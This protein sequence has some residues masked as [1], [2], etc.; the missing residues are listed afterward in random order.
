MAKTSVKNQNSA[1][2]EEN[3]SGSHPLEAQLRLRRY[4]PTLGYSLLI[5]LLYLTGPIFMMQVYDRVLAS[6]NI[7]TLIAL[8]FVVLVLYIFFGVLEYIRTQILTANGEAIVAR[9]AKPAYKLS[10]LE[11]TRAKPQD[12]KLNA[13]EDVHTL[14]S[15][16]CSP[17][18]GALFDLPWSPLFLLFVFS[19][20][21]Q[22]GLLALIA[23]IGLASLAIVNER[24]TRQS[25]QQANGISMAARQQAE[26]AQRN[27]I[28]LL[29]NGMLL[30]FGRRWR[31]TDYDAQQKG[32]AASAVNSGFSTV[33]KTVRLAIQSCMLGAGAY[34][35][36][37]GEMTAGAIIAGSVTFGR[38]LA[39]LE[40][41]LGN[42]SL[43]INGRRSWR[44]ISSWVKQDATEE[45]REPLPRPQRKLT[46]NQL[47]VIAPGSQKV[48]VKNIHFELSA[49]EVL[50]I[51]GP[52][53][54]GKSSLAKA[55]T[56]AWPQ[57]SGKICLDGAELSQYSR[58]FLGA[59]MGYVPQ[60]VELFA[61]T[62][63]ENI[64][65][66][67]PD[68]DFNAVLTASRLAGIHEMILALPDGYDT[69]LGGTCGLELSGGQRQRVALARAL[70]KLPFLL[71]LDEPNSN[72]D[73]TGENALLR[74]LKA[75]KRQGCITI[76]IA[77]RPSVLSLA[78][79]ILVM[80]DGEMKAFGAPGDIMKA[81]QKQQN[82]P[83][84][85]ENR[86][87]A[88]LAMS[89]LDAPVQVR[90]ERGEEVALS[91]KDDSSLAGN[92]QVVVPNAYG[93]F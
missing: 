80:A 17:A 38:A 34:F 4:L 85:R 42:I 63:A 61:G 35:V 72:L 82:A 79:K 22:L 15:F 27:A 75:L 64:A 25:T 67:Q 93:K 91:Q 37:Q 29:G 41:L 62:V 58:E 88:Q 43:V 40:A 59:N 44:D 56:G 49:G 24:L 5:N 7:P 65:R 19:L 86:K 50:A 83:A 39:P 6:S 20:H 81:A 70:Y 18:F 71:V 14:R 90:R 1:A 30:G 92:K 2:R 76:L 23:T 87:A 8:L 33:T 10:V 32:V 54:C 52:S 68:Y 46:V 11:R 36:V 74:A 57:V 89:K 51:S 9:L 31:K 45:D 12:A 69:Q 66:F 13:L 78:D 3:A 48:L 16:L 55:I 21:P 53:G 26:T 73:Q 84:A 77:H 28:A 60:T 47:S